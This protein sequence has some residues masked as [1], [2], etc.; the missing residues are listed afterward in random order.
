LETFPSRVSWPGRNARKPLHKRWRRRGRELRQRVRRSAW[1]LA[2]DESLAHF[3]RTSSRG[4]FCDLNRVVS[5]PMVRPQSRWRPSRS[6]GWGG[7][8]VEF[9]TS[10]AVAIASQPPTSGTIWAILGCIA[11]AGAVGGFVSS[12]LVTP[13]SWP[14]RSRDLRLTDVA[15]ILR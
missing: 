11:V 10:A 1:L 12:Q 8:A 15:D 2:L 7:P 6:A 14:R 9:T 3:A 5:G 4:W 13:A